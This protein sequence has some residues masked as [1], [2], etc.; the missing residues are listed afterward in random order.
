MKSTELVQ[1]ALHVLS[2]WISGSHPDAAEVEILR[3]SARPGEEELAVDELACLIVH[4][5]CEREL[6]ESRQE[7]EA[8]KRLA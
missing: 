6:H 1:T 8:A 3:Q 2:A 7:R 4:R 5:E